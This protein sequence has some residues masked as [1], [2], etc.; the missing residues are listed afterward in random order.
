MIKVEEIYLDRYVNRYVSSLYV[1]W[2]RCS[3]SNAHYK[4]RN[5]SLHEEYL[6]HKRSIVES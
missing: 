5:Q 6:R 4:S 1:P 2:A 3:K